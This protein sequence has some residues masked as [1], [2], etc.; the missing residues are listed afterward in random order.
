MNP[1][2]N[3]ASSDPTQNITLAAAQQFKNQLAAAMAIEFAE[4]FVKTVMGQ[5]IA[6]AEFRQS[7]PAA[8]VNL[9]GTLSG[10]GGVP[11][12]IAQMRNAVLS[13]ARN[14]N[15]VGDLLN[16]LREA[17]PNSEIATIILRI[18]GVAAAIGTLL[19]QIA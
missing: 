10:V 8:P 11:V 18:P 7:P 1:T 16:I 6:E 3:L 2:N 12:N 14:N 19:G 4:I 13:A 5:S 17:F 15:P 9:W